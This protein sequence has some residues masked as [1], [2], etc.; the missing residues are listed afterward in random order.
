MATMPVAE[1]PGPVLRLEGEIDLAVQADVAAC[2]CELVEVPAPTV[3]TVDL[4]AVTFMDCS[5]LT[6]LLVAR[7]LLD[8]R[9]RLQGAGPPVRHLLDHLHLTCLL[10]AHEM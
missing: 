10:E 2:L 3:V 4:S 9:L 1:R 6:P 5:G 7:N 8:G